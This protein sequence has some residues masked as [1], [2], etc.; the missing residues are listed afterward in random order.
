MLGLAELVK[1]LHYEVSVRL[2]FV[3]ILHVTFSRER[4]QGEDSSTSKFRCLAMQQWI[5][6]K[7]LSV[8]RVDANNSTV[9]IFTNFLDGPR[10]QSLSRK[11][12]LRL[13][14]GS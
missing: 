7:R 10:T 3:Q 14:P 9:D 13:R 8:G 1:E 5:R 2:E 4:D 6:E 12:G 11:L